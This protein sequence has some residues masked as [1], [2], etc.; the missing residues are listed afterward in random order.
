MED[1]QAEQARATLDSIRLDLES[2]SALAKVSAVRDAFRWLGE[3]GTKDI[4]SEE[5]RRLIFPDEQTESDLRREARRVLLDLLTCETPS[6][7]TQARRI[8]ARLSAEQA[9]RRRLS[10]EK[11]FSVQDAEAI[12][13]GV[14]E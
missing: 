9:R 6:A 8:G 5:V 2:E 3:L 4:P 7:R 1:F 13:R 12:L 10:G 11:G 14:D